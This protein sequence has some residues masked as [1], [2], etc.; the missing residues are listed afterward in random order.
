MFWVALST[1]LMVMTGQGDDTF[2]F[3][4]FLESLHDGIENHVTDP[5]RKERALALVADT[6]DKFRKH[7]ERV[8]EIGECIERNDR[9][10]KVSEADYVRC[11]EGAEEL[12][13]RAAEA[14]ITAERG[15]DQNITETER[16]AIEAEAQVE[17][18]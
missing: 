5:A 10:Y 3:R 18:P 6:A 14:L 8:N 7:R 16:R 12:W 2:V 13:D 15:L 4:E 17:T 11:L 1:L 9:S